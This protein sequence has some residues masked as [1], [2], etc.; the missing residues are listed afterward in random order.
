MQT[1]LLHL[2]GSSPHEIEQKIKEMF[3]FLRGKKIVQM[4]ESSQTDPA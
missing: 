1:P 4:S 3:G 2:K